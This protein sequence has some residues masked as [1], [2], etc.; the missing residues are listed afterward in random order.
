MIQGQRHGIPLAPYAYN[1]A[2]AVRRFLI[3]GLGTPPENVLYFEDAT[4]GEMEDLFRRTFPNRVTP[5]ETEV[6]VYFSGHGMPVDDKAR[7]LPADARPDTADITEYSRDALLAQL[8]RLHAASMT[9]VWTPVS[10][11]RPRTER[12]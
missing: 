5:G 1:D 11:E 4:R 3:D 12:R 8:D 9:V 10:P 7:L 6:F 2:K